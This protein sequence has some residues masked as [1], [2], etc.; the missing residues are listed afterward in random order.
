MLSSFKIEDQLMAETWFYSRQGTLTDP[1]DEPTHRKSTSR[2][3]GINTQKRQRQ[4]ANLPK[5][6]E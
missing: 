1:A 4:E 5:A 6:L 3:S 2:L